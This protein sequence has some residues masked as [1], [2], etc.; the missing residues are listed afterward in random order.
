MRLQD[1]RQIYVSCV[2]VYWAY[3]K[4]MISAFKASTRT[5]R[6]VDNIFTIKMRVKILSTVRPVLVEALKALII[7]SL[8]KN[9]T[10]C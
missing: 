1:I 2:P 10:D 6:T 9:R 7:Q 3:K 8:H 5:G 4:E